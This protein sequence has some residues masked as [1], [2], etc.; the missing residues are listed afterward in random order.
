MLKRYK[1]VFAWS[2]E[3]LKTYDTS[4]I[5]HK[6]PLKPSIKPFRKK[7]WQINPNLLSVIEGEVKNI[8]EEKI[9]V[10]LRYSEWV[11]NLVPARKKNGEIRLCVNFRNLNRS[12][13]KDNYPLPKLDHVLEKV[14]GANRISM[15]D[16]LSRY[17]QIS[18]QKDNREKN[19]FTT[20]WGTFMYDKMPFGLMNAGETF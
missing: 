5:D 14:V 4:I 6:I 10:P 19:S 3:D 17:N 8:L 15:I 9:I 2:Y 13:L 16:G 1:D 11:A 7:L 12:S 20:P 18:I